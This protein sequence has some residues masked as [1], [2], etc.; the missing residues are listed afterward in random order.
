VAVVS[1]VLWIS[2]IFLGRWIGFTTTRASKPDNDV[3]IENLFPP[4]P[5][6]AGASKNPK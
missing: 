1:L 2:I 3:N 6:D 5:D 4:A